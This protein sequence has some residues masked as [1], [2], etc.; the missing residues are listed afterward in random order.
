[1]SNII[2]LDTLGS[3]KYKAAIHELKKVAKKGHAEAQWRLG[4]L[5]AT[6]KEAENIPMDYRQAA[7]WIKKSAD[8]QFTEAENTLAWLYSNGF[9]VDHDD[10]TAGEWYI[11]AATHG[12]AKA[13]YTVGSMYRWGLHG[14]EKSVG[15]MLYWYQQAATQHFATAQFALGKLLMEAREGMDKNEAVA[16][17]WLSIAAANGHASAQKLLPELMARFSSEQLDAL[18]KQIIAQATKDTP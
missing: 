17:Q 8:Q 18:K 12:L 3:R 11:R 5:Y 4:I 16:F 14:V 13:Q 10:K 7:K 9:G 2:N 6:G 15:T 1:M